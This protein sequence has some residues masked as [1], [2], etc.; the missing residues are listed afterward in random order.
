MHVRPRFVF[1]ELLAEGRG[2]GRVGGCVC[3]GGGGGEVEGEGRSEVGGE[4]AEGYSGYRDAENTA[5]KRY[6]VSLKCKPTVV[7]MPKTCLTRNHP[8]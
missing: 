3:V 6:S 5:E 8:S 7:L 2:G 4:L 1:L